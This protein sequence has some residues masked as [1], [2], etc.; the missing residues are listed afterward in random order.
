MNNEYTTFAYRAFWRCAELIYID[1]PSKL[2]SIGNEALR[3]CDKLVLTEL[4]DSITS[5][6]ESSFRSSDKIALTKLPK[7]VEKI[8]ESC[9]EYAQ[10]LL[11]SEF[12]SN[13][14]DE[15]SS[16][17]NSIDRKGFLSAGIDVSNQLTELTFK[18][19][20]GDVD[21]PFGERA[22]EGYHDIAKVVWYTTKTRTD[23]EI[24]KI[25]AIAGLG[26]VELDIKYI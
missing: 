18:A 6:G 17:L 21:N 19:S 2:K 16:L 3:E 15:D 25:L 14:G 5:L 1:I 7:L 11:I 8:P 10:S 20:I 23:E 24:R 13:P 4:P 26:N 22:F 12:G 9:F